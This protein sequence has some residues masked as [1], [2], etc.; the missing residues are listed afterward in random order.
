MGNSVRFAG[1]NI[2]SNG[3]D[4]SEKARRNASLN[5]DLNTESEVK[6]L[7]SSRTRD[8]GVSPTNAFQR[9]AR[10]SIFSMKVAQDKL[11][12]LRDPN[13]HLT[14]EERQELIYSI[15]LD[16]LNQARKELIDIKKRKKEDQ[17]YMQKSPSPE[18]RIS[19]GTLNQTLPVFEP[20]L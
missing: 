7:E 20:K 19:K 15:L 17:R 4:G 16:Q 14:E 12:R 9:A 1:V 3:F 11:E 2:K 8:N 5:K 10:T 13:S 18:S 6:L